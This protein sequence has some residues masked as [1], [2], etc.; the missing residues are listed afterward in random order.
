GVEAKAMR[1][2]SA[3][4]GSDFQVDYLGGEEID[5]DSDLIQSFHGSLS[6]ASPSISSE[7]IS[8]TFV[9]GDL[10]QAPTD[11]WVAGKTPF[12]SIAMVAKAGAL[13]A[14]RFY[15]DAQAGTDLYEVRFLELTGFIDE[16]RFFSP[17]DAP[18]SGLEVFGCSRSG[19]RLFIDFSGAAHPLGY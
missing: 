2:H 4:G 12:A 9:V 17:G 16:G 1:T 11:L 5:P 10:L 6:G 3:P 18:T 19:D 14:N 8:R 13:R 7:V 15:G